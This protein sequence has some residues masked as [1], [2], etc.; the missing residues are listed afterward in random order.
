MSAKSGNQR[1]VLVK[2]FTFA[3]AFLVVPFVADATHWYR[4]QRLAA[5]SNR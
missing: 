3:V 5:T 2:E 4:F 1:V